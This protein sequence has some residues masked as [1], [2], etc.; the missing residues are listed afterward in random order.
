[1][2]VALL[3][4]QKLMPKVKKEIKVQGSSEAAISSKRH[5]AATGEAARHLMLKPL[6][7][8]QSLL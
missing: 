6:S 8:M 4:V 5:R 3:C 2:H 1:M 7:L